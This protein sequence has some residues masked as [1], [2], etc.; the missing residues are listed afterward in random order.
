MR[1]ATSDGC[2]VV[3]SGWGRA[4]TAVIGVLRGWAR[5]PHGNGERR[6]RECGRGVGQA[7]TGRGHAAPQVRTRA[8][9]RRAA[10]GVGA[11]GLPDMSSTMPTGK[12]E[13]KPTDP[14]SRMVV[15]RAPFTA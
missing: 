7:T 11:T 8:T 13:D 9:C 5:R 4:G 15:T 12:V 3:V 6:A 1:R 14:T 2:G 10:R